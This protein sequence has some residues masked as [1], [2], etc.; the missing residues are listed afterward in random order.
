[1]SLLMEA[2]KKAE[3]AKQQQGGQPAAEAEKST[4][5]VEAP[6]PVTELSLQPQ[7][8]AVA[9]ADTGEQDKALLR[10][11]AEA[12]PMPELALEAPAAHPETPSR[13][14]PAPPAPEPA[15]TGVE[16][17]KPQATD[18]ASRAAIPAAPKAQPSRPA[19][20]HA[21]QP[22]GATAR[23]E[24]S[25]SA[26]QQKARTVFSAKSPSRSRTVLIGGAAAAVV[27]ALAGFGF[28]YWQLVAG[29]ST[30]PAAMPQPAAVPAAAPA[31]G[32]AATP[33]APAQTAAIPAETGKAAQPPAAGT[34]PVPA[35]T[36]SEPEPARTSPAI[37]IR[38]STT[39][40]QIN[41]S[42]SKAYQAYQAGDADA[43]QQQYQKVL[44]QD[45]NNRDALLGL[46]AI[47]LGRKQPGQ[48][49]ALYT[50]LLELDPADPDALAGLVGT[51]GQ[52]DPVQS[53]TRLKKILVQNP[54]AAAV[55]FSLGNVY[56]QQSRWAEAQQA[57]FRAFSGAPANADYAFNLAVS[58]DFL[59]Q[60]KLALEYY[61]RA[62]NLAKSG[63]ANFDREAAKNRVS[64]LSPPVEK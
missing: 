24:R 2:L 42:L 57:Y 31:P 10:L 22:R 61:Q 26:A 3:R 19:A 43:A 23:D 64:E 12:A 14:E 39:P 28:Y 54:Q 49:A 1:M 13:I 9:A 4:P 11:D 25:I 21:A 7:E 51:Q 62:L 8:P 59:S 20:G 55:H 50:R 52:T 33:A 38:Q 29:S 56:S 58:L 15:R 48:A 53:E 18:T 41:P 36:Y 5:A 6:K 17:A 34:E 60:G 46:A 40:S 63:P 47:A 30:L 32:L 45:A 44:Q 35:Q 27:A 37:Q 16:P